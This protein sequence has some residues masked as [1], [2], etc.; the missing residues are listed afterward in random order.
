MTENP[1][2]KLNNKVDVKASGMN[3]FTEQKT[4]EKSCIQNYKILSKY[5]IKILK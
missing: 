4:F 1:W 2:S 3:I 5:S